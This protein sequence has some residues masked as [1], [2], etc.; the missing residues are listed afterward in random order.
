MFPFVPRLVSRV[1]LGVGLVVAVGLPAASAAETVRLLGDRQAV[2]FPPGIPAFGERIAEYAATPR[3][4]SFQWKAPEELADYVNESFYPALS[5]RMLAGSLSGRLLA[6]VEAYREKRNALVFELADLLVASQGEG[7][8]AQEAA[9]RAA[10]ET[11]NP[12]ILALEDEAEALRRDLISGGLFQT[13]VDWNRERRWVLGVSR[14][15]HPRLEAE[16][17]FQVA[18]AAIYYADGLLPEQRGLLREI[19]MELQWQARAARP[20][21]APK[22][23]SAAAMFFSPAGSRLRLPQ[24]AP[25]HLV[26]LFARFNGEKSALKAELRELVL[27]R[28][29]APARER[30]AAFEA[31]AERQWS[32]LRDL[33]KLAEEIR[34]ELARLPVPRLHAAPHIPEPLLERIEVYNTDRRQFIEEFHEALRDAMAAVRPPPTNSPLTPEE[35]TQRGQTLAERR[36]SARLLAAEEFRVKTLE[37]FEEMRHRFERIQAELGVLATGQFDRETGQPHTAETLLRAYSTAMERFEAFGREEVIYRGYRL[38]VLMPGL[39]PEQ[40]R[41]LFGAALVGLA[42]PLPSGEPMP[43]TPMPVPRS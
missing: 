1:F 25:P 43:F 16:A 24:N 34:V 33:D 39:S 10:A 17:E 35:R 3:S 30:T 40:R 32:R 5:T 13:S 26:A 6:R 7:D 12:R 42:Q 19:A 14:F 11:Q 31:L 28:D 27:A 37:R 9:L 36:A 21:P 29:N 2:C 22:L 20:I 41:L 8:A 38:A 4:G 23:H 18:R 15:S